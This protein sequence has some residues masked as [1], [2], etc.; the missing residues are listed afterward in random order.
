MFDDLLL[1]N[2]ETGLRRGIE[3]NKV[4]AGQFGFFS[5][6]QR[7][8]IAKQRDVFCECSND[9]SILLFV[10]APIVDAYCHTGLL[11][12]RFWRG[13]TRSPFDWTFQA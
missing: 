5:Q 12:L 4:N 3:N 7:H 13:L 11:F 6:D 9:D 1:S 10:F 8:E 2:F